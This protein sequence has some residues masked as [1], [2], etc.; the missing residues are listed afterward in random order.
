[1]VVDFDN[2]AVDVVV[3]AQIDSWIHG[4]VDDS[5][6]MNVVDVVVGD[7]EDNGSYCYCRLYCDYYYCCCYHYCGYYVV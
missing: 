4:I 2:L 3:V 5:G 6:N 1:M 7:D